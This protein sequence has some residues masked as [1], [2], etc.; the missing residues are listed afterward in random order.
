MFQ[1]SEVQESPVFNRRRSFLALWH[2]CGRNRGGCLPH[3]GFKA[4]IG[5]VAVL[6]AR[7]LLGPFLCHCVKSSRMGTYLVAQWRLYGRRWRITNNLTDPSAPMTSATSLPF[8]PQ[9]PVDTV[10]AMSND[11][12]RNH[13]EEWQIRTH[14][15]DR[16]QRLPRRA[17]VTTTKYTPHTKNTSTQSTQMPF[18]G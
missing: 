14:R 18:M 11:C 5:P 17:L 13:I 9:K 8:I 7:C 10:T 2:A 12:R 15:L 1:I 6:L 3:R 16:E 4:E